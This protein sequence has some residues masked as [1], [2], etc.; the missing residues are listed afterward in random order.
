MVI[1]FLWVR[2]AHGSYH[3]TNF[4]SVQTLVGVARP[5]KL[6]IDDD[7]SIYGMSVYL[8][9]DHQQ[10]PDMICGQNEGNAL[11]K[12]LTCNLG[13]QNSVSFA[14][15]RCWLISTVCFY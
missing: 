8:N 13:L 7:F 10:T 5:Q 14:H 15:G 4:P 1:N 12:W 2:V 3:I 6:G 9:N 11:G